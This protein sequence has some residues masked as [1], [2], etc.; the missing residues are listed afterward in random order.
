MAKKI[1]KVIFRKEKSGDF[2]GSLTAVFPESL[3]DSTMVNHGNIMCYCH[4]GQ[5]CEGS[6]KW[7]QQRTV[8]A[9][10][11]EYLNL[12]E[13]IKSIYES[14]GDCEIKVVQK[15]NYSYRKGF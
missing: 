15:M 8:K 13:E 7:Y 5:H 3:N 1:V 2:K 11:E 12:L 9:N 10:P 6:I 14:D 4:L